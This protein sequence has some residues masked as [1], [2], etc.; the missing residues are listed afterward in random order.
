MQGFG[1][2]FYLPLLPVILAGLAEEYLGGC[3][4][5]DVRQVVGGWN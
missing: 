5:Q 3:F 1:G 2:V 4:T